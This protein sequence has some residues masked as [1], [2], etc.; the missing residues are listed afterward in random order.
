MVR[1]CTSATTVPSAAAATVT[2]ST[3]GGA[4]FDLHTSSCFSPFGVV[5]EAAH[6]YEDNLLR[7][8]DPFE[9][10]RE[11]V[12]EELHDL[13]RPFFPKSQP[14]S[15]QTIPIS[16]LSV[17][18]GF[19]EQTIQT[20]QIQ[21]PQKKEPPSSS[22]HSHASSVASSTVHSQSPRSKRR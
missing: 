1:G 6:R 9:T 10:R 19:S 11:V 4:G 3:S 2:A 12:V 17:I 22:K 18:G 16:S 14:L 13:Y 7:F 15:P 8:P 20:H 21:Q 5:G